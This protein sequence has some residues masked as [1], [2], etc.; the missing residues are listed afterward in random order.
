LFSGIVTNSDATN[1]DGNLIANLKWTG[2]YD[3]RSEAFNIRYEGAV[4]A[5][6][7]TDLILKNNYASGSQRVGYWVPGEDC[8][9]TD[10]N[11]ENNVAAGNLMG[12][13]VMIH[14][15]IPYSCAR[16]AGF[17]VFKNRDYGIYYN[18]MP[19]LEVKDNIFADN[20]AALFP[21]VVEPNP[22]SHEC[23]DKTITLSDSIFIGFSSGSNCA[24]ETA[25]TGTYINLS[26][27][28][29]GPT[30]PNGESVGVLFPQFTGGGNNAPEKP[31]GNIM[32]YNTICGKMT[33]TS[34]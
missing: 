16:Y 12:V 23:S 6:G 24:G 15:P 21:M 22:L 31:C 14:D 3:G 28:C 19:S 8:T 34:K 2:S 17:T 25:A 30:G 32:S 26:G 20:T 10:T 4:A 33:M 18:N 5:I 29:R 13:A 11:Y 27:H 9:S 1:I 7:S